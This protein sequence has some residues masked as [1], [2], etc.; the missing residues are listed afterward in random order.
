MIWAAFL[1][2]MLYFWDLPDFS[3][4]DAF[5]T[6]RRLSS[7]SKVGSWS[8]PQVPRR[9]AGALSG[10]LASSTAGWLWKSLLRN[11]DQQTV[12]TFIWFP[13]LG[14]TYE[15]RRKWQQKS[16]RLNSLGSKHTCHR[17][18]SEI[19]WDIR[20]NIFLLL[21]FVVVVVLAVMVVVVWVWFFWLQIFFQYLQTEK[22]RNPLLSL[23][24]GEWALLKI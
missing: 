16:M 12:L 8:S 19:G 5:L 4:I 24:S 13:S 15:I 18:N 7:M 1:P 9:Q 10:P 21:F 23:H 6:T 3:E 22:G 20:S 11:N 2:L 17:L 14:V